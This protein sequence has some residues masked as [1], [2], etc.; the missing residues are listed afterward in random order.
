[1]S[2]KDLQIVTKLFLCTVKDSII[3]FIYFAHMNPV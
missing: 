3:A 1:M 2:Q